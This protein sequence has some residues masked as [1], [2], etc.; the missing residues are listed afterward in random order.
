MASNGNPLIAQGFLNR[1][2]GAASVTDVPALNVSA[3]YLAK[4]GISLRTMGPSTDIIP[5]MTG[6][7]GSQVPYMQAEIVIHLLRTQA[8]GESWRQRFLSDTLL[9]E[10]VV[11]TD[12]TV[13]GDFTILNTY[14]TNFQE[15][16]VN[17]QDAGFIVT[18]SGYW[19]VNNNMW[20]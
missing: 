14:L 5:T 3:S 7:V 15:L 2:K 12:S 17:G 11:T 1:V 8:L 4:E 16:P 13:M 6:T 19:V 20:S 9:G 18:L 10:V